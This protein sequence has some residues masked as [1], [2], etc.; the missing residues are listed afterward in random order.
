MMSTKEQSQAT[1]RMFARVIGPFLT[2]V[3]AT[4]AVR[5]PELWKDIPDFAADPLWNWVAGAF[6]L[7]AGLVVVALHPYWRGVAAISVSGLGWLTAIKG[8]FLLAFPATIMSVPVA[9]MGA[10]NWWRAVYV[11][12]ALLGLY[13]T[14][15]GWSRPPR[16]SVPEAAQP[17]R[18]L[19][20][21]A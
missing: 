9:A 6:T 15:V 20:H 19:P 2:V 7:L 17:T 11:A 3:T 18:D 13:L 21:A 8:L 5:A 10:V 4:A 14:F 12:F 1:T 16:R